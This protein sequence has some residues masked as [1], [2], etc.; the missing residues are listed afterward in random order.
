M[1]VAIVEVAEMMCMTEMVMLPPCARV[2]AK[3]DWGNGEAGASQ[4]A[5]LATGV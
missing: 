5:P 4:A 3:R 1:W 2:D